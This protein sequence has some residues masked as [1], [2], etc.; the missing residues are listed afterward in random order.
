MRSLHTISKRDDSHLR[1]SKARYGAGTCNVLSFAYSNL[2]SLPPSP[3]FLLVSYISRGTLLCT[4]GAEIGCVMQGPSSC[5]T[6][7]ASVN[8]RV[9]E[10]TA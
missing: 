1:V 7:T 10:L 2:A 5:S 6:T 8:H 3:S 9:V 4:S